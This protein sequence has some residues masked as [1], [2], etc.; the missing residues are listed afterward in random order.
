MVP[1][2]AY[3]QRNGRRVEMDVHE[4]VV[5]DIVEVKYGDLIPADIR[6]VEC[7]DLKV[8]NSSLTGESEPCKRSVLVTLKALGIN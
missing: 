3:V 5:G 8:D 1:R 7:Q 2:S 4:L 6:V